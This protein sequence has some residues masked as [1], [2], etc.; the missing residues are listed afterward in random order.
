[1]RKGTAFRKFKEVRATQKEQ[2]LD[3]IKK[4]ESICTSDLIVRLKMKHQTVT[5]RLSELEQDG[6]IYQ[7]GWIKKDGKSS[8][9]IWKVTPI[10]LIGAR[11]TENW[12]KRMILWLEK[13]KRNGFISEKETNLLKKQST[14]F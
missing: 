14:L 12:N 8:Y 6:L 4:N 9:T 13:G 3:F 5:G 11:K 10:E 1:M 7:S 2:V